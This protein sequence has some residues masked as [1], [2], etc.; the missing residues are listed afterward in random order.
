MQEVVSIHEW[1]VAARNPCPFCSALRNCPYD[2]TPGNDC[3]EHWPLSTPPARS[4][5]TLGEDDP[6]LRIARANPA[7]AELIDRW[8]TG[9]RLT[10]D[11]YLHLRELSDQARTD[12]AE[13]AY[14]LVMQDFLWSRTHQQYLDAVD[15]YG[16]SDGSA[17]NL[18]CLNSVGV[19]GGV[20]L[21][22]EKMV[23]NDTSVRVPSHFE[24]IVLEVQRHFLWVVAG[25]PLFDLS[26]DRTQ[27]RQQVERYW[28]E[29]LHYGNGFH[30]FTVIP[31]IYIDDLV[32]YQRLKECDSLVS[33]SISN[34]VIWSMTA[35]PN[36]LQTLAPAFG[37]KAFGARLVKMYNPLIQSYANRLVRRAEIVDGKRDAPDR[38]DV[39]G[40]LTA[41][42]WHAIKEYKFSY[43]K[44]EAL[45]ASMGMIGPESSP[46]WRASLQR[47]FDEFQLPITVRD[48]VHVGFTRYV[49]GK[50]DEHLRECYPW[51]EPEF[52]EKAGA[53]GAIVEGEGEAADVFREESSRTGRKRDV[54]PGVPSAYAAADGTQYLYVAQMAHV[55]GVTVHQ[56]R[57]WDRRGDLET[58]RLGDVDPFAPDSIASRRVYPYT[59]EVVAQIQRLAE[60][61]DML[62]ADP[63]EGLLSRKEAAKRLGVTA[64]TVDNWREQG[65][66][67]AVELDHRVFIPEAEVERILAEREAD[68]SASD[69]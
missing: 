21:A 49:V 48:S 18:F 50:F 33:W 1:D 15:Y 6:H 35:F 3:L 10:D 32:R 14:H 59:S 57:N 19:W 25:M 16:V 27:F 41:L 2:M 51:H 36:P 54:G 53:D 30:G 58:L 20:V 29:L 11:D 23:H 61:K 38:E 65:K 40:E 60:R 42:L 47:R 26:R 55:C 64:R 24:R 46:E 62:Q 12:E 9:E 39:V 7:V 43:G 17:D 28:L 4:F 31:G 13:A 5:P 69:E 56:L 37:E 44:P 22:N 68:A 8:M 52:G 34:W 45:L 67:E 63:K 66:I